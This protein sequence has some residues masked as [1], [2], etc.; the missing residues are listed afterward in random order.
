LPREVLAAPVS[1]FI[2]TS[3]SRHATPSA[4]YPPPRAIHDAA[5]MRACAERPVIVTANAGRDEDDVA[6]LAA[7]AE[8]FAIPVTQRKPRYMALPTN[9]PMHL[10]YEPDAL[11]AN[12]DLV[13]VAE[14]DVPWIPSKKA[15]PR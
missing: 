8:C 3:P 13:I 15:P 7:L 12:A 6:K 14:C 9:H 1:N 11:L 10:G 5:E 2:Y 4:P